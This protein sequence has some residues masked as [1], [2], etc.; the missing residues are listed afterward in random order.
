MLDALGFAAASE[1]PRAAVLVLRGKRLQGWN[2]SG[3]G[4]KDADPQSIEFS[5][6][7]AGVLGQAVHAKKSVTM[8][9]VPRDVKVP[10][11][12]PLS[13]DRM[14]LAVPVIVGGR[15]LA[16]VYADSV[17]PEGYDTETPSGWPELIEVLARHAGRCLE[18]LATRPAAAPRPHAESSR[19]DRLNKPSAA[20]RYARVLFG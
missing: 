2:A 15:V 7:E 3:F 16:V 18:A 1:A 19:P 13:P 12:H 6:D 9:E 4:A 10:G 5:I 20:R 17:T 8:R 14:G 11:F